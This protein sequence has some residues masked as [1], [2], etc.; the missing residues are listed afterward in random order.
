MKSLQS[1]YMHRTPAERSWL[2]WLG[3]NGRLRLAWSCWLNRQ[4]YSLM[5]GT[6][7]GI[8]SSRQKLLQLWIEG[9]WA[10]MRAWTGRLDP[11]ALTQSSALLAEWRSQNADFSELFVIDR[12]GKVLASSDKHHLGKTDLHPDAVKRGLAQPF[13][14]GPYRDPF[15]L[16]LGATSSQ[17]HDAMTLMFYQPLPG[18]GC[19]CGRIPNDAMSDILQREDGHVFRDS[20]DNYLFMAKAVFDPGIAPGTALSRSRFEDRTFTLG[21]NLKQGVKTAFGTVSVKEHTELELRFTDPAT[22]ELHPG[23]RETIQRG[24]NLFVTYPGYSDYRH[25]PV[26]GKGITFSV[27]GSPDL[28]GMM[29][30]GDLEEVYR[31]RPLLYRMGKR[32]LITCILT[33]ATGELLRQAGLLADGDRVAMAAGWATL[34]AAVS[35]VI[36]AVQRLEKQSHFL[37]NLAECSASLRQRLEWKTLA[38]DEVGELGRWIN[39]FVD[40]IDDTVQRSLEVAKRVGTASSSLNRLATQVSDGSQ[41]QRTSAQVSVSAI[42]VLA[43]GSTAMA[44]QSDAAE[45]IA[46]DARQL[47]NHGAEVIR[48]AMAEMSLTSTAIH[49]MAGR[50][51]ALDRRAEEINRILVVIKAIAD[52]TNLLALNAAIEA[53]RAGEQGRGF[54]VV[55]DEV[56]SLAQRTA[57]STSE[58]TAMIDGVQNETRAAVT[59][60]QQC[61]TQVDRS[62]DLVTQ[63][64]NALTRIN[65]GAGQAVTE[66]ANITRSAHQQLSTGTQIATQVHTIAELADAN[67]TQAQQALT[68]ARDLDQLSRD[69]LGVMGKFSV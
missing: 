42:Q 49:E 48:E 30:E 31:R 41:Q 10:Q 68:A 37:L 14:H 12:Q 62:V 7:T 43:D 11:R 52:Q 28:W 6:F 64:G 1:L 63:A 36:P 58:I 45:A 8:A 20:G 60:M 46:R 34:V 51:N 57:N 21:D 44:Q 40:K 61:Q 29:C 9:Q 5:E 32:G 3:I 2:P 56:R 18:I 26:I 55:A 15:T 4:R 35:A 23:V 13:L 17:F 19:L 50:V 54:S 53:A 69:L 59:M 24:E 39:S 66:V 27:P 47:S 22:R 33:L 67:N 25:I 38:A 65:E 16:R